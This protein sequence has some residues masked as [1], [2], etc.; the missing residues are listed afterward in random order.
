MFPYL[1]IEADVAIM[2]S[3]KGTVE[4]NEI[5][6]SIKT[7]RALDLQNGSFGIWA[8]VRDDCLI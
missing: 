3:F 1:G 5:L 4:T 7:P 2:L 6:I 8:R